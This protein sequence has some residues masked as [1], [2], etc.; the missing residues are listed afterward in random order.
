MEDLNE[1]RALVKQA[2]RVKINSKYTVVTS[3]PP[4]SGIL[5]T[6]ILRIMKG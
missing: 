4:S 2:M 1:Y 5:V 3:P 6:A